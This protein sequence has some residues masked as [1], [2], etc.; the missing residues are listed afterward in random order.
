MKVAINFVVSCSANCTEERFQTALILLTSSSV[1]K[2][3][4]AQCE[5]FTFFYNNIAL[6]I[7]VNCNI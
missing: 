6:F 2:K 4:S 1:C 3:I 5:A 7:L